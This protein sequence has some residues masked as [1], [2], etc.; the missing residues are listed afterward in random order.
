[1]ND[2]LRESTRYVDFL[3]YYTRLMENISNMRLY[4]DNENLRYDRF[5]VINQLN[6][7]CQD[8]FNK[9]FIELNQSEE[10]LA[11]MAFGDFLS[12]Y[13][14]FNSYYA[15]LAQNNWQSL[16]ESGD[17]IFFLDGMDELPR[18]PIEYESRT[19][20]IEEFTQAWPNIAFVISCRELDYN[21]ELEFDQILI[22]PFS[23]TKIKKYMKIYF[24]NKNYKQYY[25][26][27]LNSYKLF[28]ICKNP[29]YLNL[30]CY[31]IKFSGVLPQNKPQLFDFMIDQVIEREKNKYIDRNDICS[32]EMFVDFLSELSYFISVKK[33]STTIRLDEF[34]YSNE[35]NY[36]KS[37]RFSVKSGIIELNDIT[38]EIR[39][40]HNRIQEYFS[41]LYIALNYKRDIV[42]P[43]NFFTNIW[44]RETIL[45]VASMDNEINDFVK[46]LLL[47]KSQY[48]NQSIFLQKLIQLDI[49]ILA[50][51]CI[52]HSDKFDDQD[53]Y[54]NVQS[55]LLA[56]YDEGNTLAK[57]K[58]LDSLKYDKSDIAQKRIKNA[59]NDKSYWVSERAFF[60][61]SDGNLL[62]RLNSISIL[63]EFLRFFIEGRIISVFPYLIKASSK[64][65]KIK[66][67]LPFYIFL[68]L[69]NI[70]FL[71]SIVYVYSYILYFIVFKLDIAFTIE[72]LSC[73]SIIT[74]GFSLITYHLINNDNYIMKRF[75]IITPLSIMVLY[76]IFNLTSSLTLKVIASIVG[77]V[78]NSI[79]KFT[80]DRYRNGSSKSTSLALHTNLLL[81][82]SVISFLYNEASNESESQIPFAAEINNFVQNNITNNGI[83]NSFDNAIPMTETNNIMKYMFTITIGILLYRTINYFKIFTEIR[84]NRNE[85][86]NILDLRTDDEKVDLFINLI[87]KTKVLW[88]KKILI[89]D[90]MRIL[91]KELNYEREKKIFFLNLTNEKIEDEILKDN[92]FQKIEQEERAYRRNISLD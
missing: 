78:F 48:I 66:Y 5:A 60:I 29:F 36:E 55:E 22:K 38:H 54:K 23:E 65:R 82:Y 49:L 31:Y 34:I 91:N 28:E 21:S 35:Y 73:L 62:M 44:W 80:K 59:L 18:N 20:A 33:M 15:F 8:E 37:L 69:C 47:Q 32:K 61:L 57:V 14:D 16:A 83:V 19:K 88:G 89:N 84:K 53:T 85:L 39:F 87:H 92:I 71:G 45:L 67:F 40:A 27:A 10:N 24:P 26:E 77:L 2:K 75:I 41:S 46:I 70:M 42:L 43:S 6:I 52:F 86:R 68:L 81:G 9:S 12:D 1:M 74:M 4:G 90:L 50:F 56:H 11:I 76:L 3:P 13:F 79:Y 17:C 30:F 58:I 25:I 51:E 72:C 63:K 7:I 64:S